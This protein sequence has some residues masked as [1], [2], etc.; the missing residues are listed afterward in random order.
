MRLVVVGN[1]VAGVTC[2]LRV[3]AQDPHAHITLVSGEAP[4]FFSRTALM[5]LLMER[6]NR[7][8]VEPYERR[9]WDDHQIHR[10][11]DW[12][13]D[14]DANRK[15]VALKGGTTL[16]Y[17]KLLLALGAQPRKAAWEGLSA[18]QSGVVNLVSMQDVEQVERAAPGVKRAVVVGGGLIGVEL[19]E[20]L[21]H[22]GIQTTFLIREPWYWPMALGP[23][24]SL[25][26]QNH[27]RSRGVDVRVDEQVAQV[28]ADASGRVSGL[29]TSRGQRLE[30]G[31][32]GVCIGVEPA[33]SAARSWTTAPTVH[34]G[35]LVDETLHTSLPDVWAAGDCAE[36]QR[37]GGPVV[38]TLWYT[39]KRHGD[40]AARNMLGEATPDVPP[41]FF[42]SSKFFELEFTTVG[43]VMDAPSGAPSELL[44]FPQREACIRVVHDGERVLGFNVLG[45]RV[46]HEVLM[47]WVEQKRA[48]A[49]VMENLHLA[50]FDEEFSRLNLR[51]AHRTSVPLRAVGA[52]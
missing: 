15:V 39:A 49:W 1:G 48:P 46:D 20:C 42:N 34:R 26:V 11:M 35:V 40:V 30:C 16:P 33:V 37:A 24:E 13:T 45:C 51:R 27:L 14:L 19:V 22:A 25:L 31:L 44:T 36:V 4:Y 6:M 52:P 29:T 32:L 43:H 2:A 21:V 28:H 17:D 7:R 18:V 3:R 41:T 47:G 5:Y 12:V 8:D 38:E 10:V 23:E 9:F 50:Q